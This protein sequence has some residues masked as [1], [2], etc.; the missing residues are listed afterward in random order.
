MFKF[1][2]LSDEFMGSHS[3][4]ELAHKSH[5]VQNANKGIIYKISVR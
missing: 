5:H 4:H 3:F 1:S 2:L